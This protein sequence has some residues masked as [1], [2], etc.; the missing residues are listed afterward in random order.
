MA[1]GRGTLRVHGVYRYE[2]DQKAAESPG[3]FAGASPPPKAA[4]RENEK[5]ARRVVV[6]GEGGAEGRLLLPLTRGHTLRSDGAA[7]PHRSGR[8]GRGRRNNGHCRPRN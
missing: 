3:Q 5:E 8:G 6:G 4:S 1:E 2:L 7:R